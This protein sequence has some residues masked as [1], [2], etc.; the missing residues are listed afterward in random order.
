LLTRLSTDKNNLLKPALNF[1]AGKPI[2]PL[3][4]RVLAVVA[5]LELC[6]DWQMVAIGYVV[7]VVTSGEPAQTIEARQAVSRLLIAKQLVV[8]EH[9]SNCVELGQPMLDLL[10]GGKEATPLEITESDLWRR[11]RK[12][13][14]SFESLPTAKQLAAKLSESVI[15]LDEQVRTFA[16]RVALHQRRASG[17][18]SGIAKRDIVVHRDERLRK[19]LARGNR[20]AGVRLTL[21]SGQFNGSDRRRLCR[22]KRRRRG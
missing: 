5:Y 9:T 21:R 11:W 12:A 2:D 3:P 17:Q 10:S 22:F 8:R 20:W 14:A 1:N 6:T 4:L 7:K 18:R 19:N 16:C 15:G 13:K